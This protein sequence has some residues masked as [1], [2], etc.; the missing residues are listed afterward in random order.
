MYRDSGLRAV[1][2]M[3]PGRRRPPGRELVSVTPGLGA[4][5]GRLAGFPK[6]WG[7]PESHL[8]TSEHSGL[9]IE[10][11]QRVAAAF[12]LTGFEVHIVAPG[13]LIKSSSGK[14]ARA[15]NR[16]QWRNGPGTEAARVG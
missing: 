11:R 14:I 13:W 10:V 4:E 5:P 8:P 1:A 7:A 12:D 6:N 2:G 9:V 16:T 15:E 3:P